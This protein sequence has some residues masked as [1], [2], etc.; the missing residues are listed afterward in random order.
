M[1]TVAY[2]N[3]LILSLVFLSMTA[4]FS[5]MVWFTP[6]QLDDYGYM[7]HYLVYNDGQSDLSWKGLKGVYDFLTPMEYVRMANIVASVVTLHSGSW[8]LFAL[9]SGLMVASLPIFILK[10]A[11][12]NQGKAFYYILI[13]AGITLFLPWRDT[14]FVKDYALNYIYPACWNLLFLLFMAN[15][16]KKR[17]II[18]SWILPILVAVSYTHLTLPTTT[19]V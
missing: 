8:P 10:L 19:R 5:L 1:K 3:N 9:I 6:L 16:D 14:L 12:V 13:W 18:L 11:K 4:I 7:R 15:A 2:R 17:G